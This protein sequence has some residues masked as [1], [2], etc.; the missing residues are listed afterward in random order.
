V[1][2]ARRAARG[3]RVWQAHREH[4]YQRAVQRG[5]SHAAVVRHV[6]AVNVVLVGLAA[7]AAAGRPGIAFA[8]AVL[9]V[10]T[11]LFFLGWPGGN[12]SE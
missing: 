12:G 6:L 10:G 2:L 11:L 8:G 1:T 9:A 4:F 7:V 5:H 3:E